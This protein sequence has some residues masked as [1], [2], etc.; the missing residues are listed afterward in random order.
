MADKIMISVYPIGEPVY[1]FDHM[2]VVVRKVK[3]GEIHDW[4]RERGIEY[5]VTEHP[6]DPTDSS[7]IFAFNF[8]ENRVYETPEEA[9][10]ERVA[11]IESW[12][13][14]GSNT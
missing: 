12:R 9:E 1:I 8:E 4:G 3:I 7:L 2:K 11:Y 5:R 6:D 14:Q 10:K 13:K